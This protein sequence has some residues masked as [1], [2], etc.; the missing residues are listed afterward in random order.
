M[1]DHSLLSP[2]TPPARSPSWLPAAAAAALSLALYAVTLHGTYIFDD[3]AIILEDPRIAHPHLWR[4]Y[5]TDQYFPDAP[6]NLY[7]PLVSMSYALQWRLHGDR[8]WAFHLVNWLL[9]AAAAAAVAEFVR[10]SVVMALAGAAGK[11][12][13]PDDGS[14]RGIWA[15]LIAGL[16]FAAHPV[17]VEAVAGIVGRAEL[18][19]TLAVFAGLCLFLAAP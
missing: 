1:T 6:D 2:S 3:R 19:C 11:E 15:G 10:R 5:W 7:R 17:H 18:A 9:A 14:R 16:S 12:A 8:A 4:E 13:E